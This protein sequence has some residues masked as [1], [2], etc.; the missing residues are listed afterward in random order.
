MPRHRLSLN[1]PWDFHI[2]TD[3][4]NTWRTITVPGAWQ[5]QFADL[6]EKPGA[7]TYQR[8]FT[9]PAEWAGHAAIL[10]F[11]AVDYWAEV[12]VNGQPVGHH[13]GGYLPFEFDISP[14]LRPSAEN[15]LRVRVLD[16]GDDVPDGLSP[17]SEVPHGKQSWYGAMGGLWQAVWLERRAPVHIQALTLNVEP[18]AGRVTV[19]LALSAPAA[20]SQRVVVQVRAPD[21][22]TVAEVAVPLAAGAV[23]A[24]AALTV[25]DAQWWS[26]DEPNLYQLTAAL[27]ADDAL[28]DETAQTFGFR[29]IAAKAGVLYLNG[30]RLYLRAALDQDYYPGTFYTP[31]SVAF[32]E[33]TMRKAKAMGLNCLRCH[34]KVPDPDYLDAADRA[35]VLVWA[36]L[37]NWRH[38]TPAVGDLA[39]AT[40]NGIV[41]RDHHHPAIIIWTI[42]NEGWGLDLKDD[43]THRAW[44]KQAYH[45]MKALDP[46][47][48]VVDNSACHPNFHIESDLD[49]FHFYAALPDHRERWDNFVNEYATRPA[50]TYSPHGDAVRTGR[51]PLLVSEFGNWGLPDANA[52]RDAVGREPWWFETGLEWG[53]GIVYPHGVQARFRRWGLAAVFGSWE[54]FITATQWHEYAALKYQIEAMRRHANIVGYVV[55][56][57]TDVHWECNG[58]LDMQRRPKAFFDQL[59]DLNAD[60]VITPGWARTAYWAGEAIRVDV[61]VSHGMG[62]PLTGAALVWRPALDLLGWTGGGGTR[63]LATLTAGAAVDVGA[64][65]LT[66]PDVPALAGQV[67]RI[68]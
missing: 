41:A 40:L 57:F 22:L 26:P 35:G 2:D 37:P 67:R 11:G 47:R 5:A 61:T 24:E 53:E 30:E 45:W 48:L 63:P 8:P 7:A 50:W 6:A 34:I 18:V 65:A 58:L 29:T 23:D 10:H 27:Y 46:T 49:D 4:A 17:F 3:P 20:V 13:E 16:P 33:D 9:V 59:A 54:A 15:T 14:Y 19:K 64:L 21:S 60:T 55:T 28:T 25:P 36:E 43:A 44:L 52:L 31:P 12:W 39:Y 56:E 38:F 42:I 62:A 51:E 68:Q 32:L 1:G 66:A